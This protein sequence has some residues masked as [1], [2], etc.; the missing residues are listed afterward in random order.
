MC[1]FTSTMPGSSVSV[2]SALN[3]SALLCRAPV[4]CSAQSTALSAAGLAPASLLSSFVLEP[5]RGKE[6]LSAAVYL[7]A[8]PGGAAIMQTVFCMMLM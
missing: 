4:L 7:L 8:E 1:G 5:R 3:E 2:C 6:D